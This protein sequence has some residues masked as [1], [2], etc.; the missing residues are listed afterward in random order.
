[1][2]RW[3]YGFIGREYYF[4]RIIKLIKYLNDEYKNELKKF[5]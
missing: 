4:E 2:K 5:Y 1:M 3:I